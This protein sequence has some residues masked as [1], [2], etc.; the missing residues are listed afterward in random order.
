MYA[1][2]QI[3]IKRQSLG[4]IAQYF[5][6]ATNLN[7]HIPASNARTINDRITQYRSWGLAYDLANDTTKLADAGN[8]ASRLAT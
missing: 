5:P 1:A 2:L 8:A 7:E 4:K 6:I 3:T